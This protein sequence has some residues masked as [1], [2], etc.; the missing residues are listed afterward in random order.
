MEKT[1]KRVPFV[2]L[3]RHK[4]SLWRSIRKK[5]KEGKCEWHAQGYPNDMIWSPCWT[6]HLTRPE[7]WLLHLLHDKLYGE[8]WYVVDSLGWEQVNYILFNNI[9]YRVIAL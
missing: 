2:F 4:A 7:Y 8:D 9:K 5:A 6:T 1:Y 3:T